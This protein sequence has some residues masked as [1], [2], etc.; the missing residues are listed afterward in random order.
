M[1]NAR[2]LYIHIPFCVKKCK[3]CDFTSYC[4]K[5]ELI[6]EYISAVKKEAYMYKGEEIDSIFIG[7]GTP[8]LMSEREIYNLFDM[9][10][11]N[12]IID[13]S[14]EITVEVNPDTATEDKISAFCK[15]GVN[16]ISMG[17]QSFED[18]EL[19]TLGR[20]H[21]SKKALLAANIISRYTNNY[22]FD[23]MTALPNQTEASLKKTLETAV[24][25]NPAHLSCYSLIIEEGTPFYE[26]YDEL[27]VPDE[28][29]DRKM[30]RMTVD[31]L[32]EN[33]YRQYEISN[34]AK[35]GYECR[36][37]LKY[38]DC[39]EYIGLG[40]AA[41]SY[42]KSERFS[43][44]GSID[45][46]LSGYTKEESKYIEEKDKISEFIIMGLRKT[47]GIDVDDFYR[48]FGKNIY[49]LFGDILNK[50]ISG[51]FLEKNGRFL[52]FTQ[53]GTDVSNSILC[54]FV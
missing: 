34:F 49:E 39:M 15:S 35:P 7:G 20:I 40:A 30:Y 52:R 6:P 22:S 50:Y 11:N 4:G 3:Y 33:G 42:Y 19:Q 29:A 27:D 1:K 37:N 13:K 8:S 38:W 25:L 51:G 9:I 26:M 45:K 54:E 10:N 47:E 5:E 17:V 24:S 2:G 28:E 36:H 16:R 46:Y 14:C 18:G 32:K 23:I 44:T 12:F 43:N 53:S 48:R 21:T 31:F 41:H